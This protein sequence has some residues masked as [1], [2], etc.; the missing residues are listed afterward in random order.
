MFAEVIYTLILQAY[1]IQHPLCCF[2]HSGIRVALPGVEGR[3]LD[4][5]TS[6]L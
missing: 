1:A 6:N 4:D 5:D 3:S 2:C